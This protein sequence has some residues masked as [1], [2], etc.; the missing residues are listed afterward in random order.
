MITP[1]CG[2][3]FVKNGIEF[4]VHWVGN[5]QVYGVR[6]REGSDYSAL[7]RGEIPEGLLGTCRLDL[8]DFHREVA[9]AK[10]IERV[11]S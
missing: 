9:D 10:Y 11:L 4:T 2:D 7:D 8:D 3:R 1:K 5:G 6:Y